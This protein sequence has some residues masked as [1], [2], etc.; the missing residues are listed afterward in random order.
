[1]AGG[2]IVTGLCVCVDLL[3][4]LG[5]FIWYIVNLV[6]VRAAVAEYADRRGY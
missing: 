5:F 2:V 1:M 4:A 3:M 6:Q